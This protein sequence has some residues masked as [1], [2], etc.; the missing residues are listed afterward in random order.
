M[1]T[2]NQTPTGPEKRFNLRSIGVPEDKYGKAKLAIT[3]MEEVRHVEVDGRG[4]MHVLFDP[5][6]STDV[7]LQVCDAIEVILRKHIS[8]AKPRIA[9]SSKGYPRSRR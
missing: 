8:E 5:R 3:Q 1:H 7:L 6:R 9:S 4:I 2:L